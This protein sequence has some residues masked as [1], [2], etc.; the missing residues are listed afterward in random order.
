M[1]GGGIILYLRA[2]H[3]LELG[4]QELSTKETEEISN[5]LRQ[6][7]EVPITTRD[8]FRNYLYHTQD[9]GIRGQTAREAMMHSVKS[10][11]LTHIE[12]SY[13]LQEVGVVLLPKL[14][15]HP[16]GTRYADA[17]EILYSHVWYDINKDNTRTY[18]HAYY[19]PGEQVFN[20]SVNGPLVE[21]AE[22]DRVTGQY[23]G[24]RGKT[25]DAASYSRNTQRM[26]EFPTEGMSL[27]INSSS[28]IRTNYT[29]S[30][31]PKEMV[32]NNEWRRPIMW[33]AN[34]SN[35]YAFSAHDSIALPPLDADHPF[36]GFG[37]VQIST[38]F[39]FHSWD[40]IINK[41]ED[42]NTIRF[43]YDRDLMYI[44]SPTTNARNT[45]ECQSALQKRIKSHDREVMEKCSGS[46]STSNRRIQDLVANDDG[47]DTFSESTI[48]GERYYVSYKG[49]YSSKTT[50]YGLNA[51]NDPSNHYD[52]KS[53][54]DLNIA[55]VWARRSSVVREE[56]TEVI[57][58]FVV[59]VVGVFMMFIILFTAQLVIIG[60]PMKALVSATEAMANL[61]THRAHEVIQD[62]SCDCTLVRVTEVESLMRSFRRT[63]RFMSEYRAFMPQ[64]LRPDAHSE[65]SDPEQERSANV[66]LDQRDVKNLERL[67]NIGLKS[68]TGSV[69][70]ARF[71]IRDFKEG[72][73]AVKAMQFVNIVLAAVKKNSGIMLQ[74][75]PTVCIATWNTH[76]SCMRH[77]HLACFCALEIKKRSSYAGF[78]TASVVATG[79]LMAGSV[80]DCNTRAVAASGGVL[81]VVDQVSYLCGYLGISVLISADTYDRVRASVDA[82]VVD[83]VV[84]EGAEQRVTLVYELRSEIKTLPNS[85][86]APPGN[87]DAKD[88]YQQGWMLFTKGKFREACETL[89]QVVSDDRQV[90]RLLNLA[91]LFEKRNGK[92]PYVRKSRIP[93]E[94][95]EL[96]L[97]SSGWHNDPS[98]VSELT[99]HVSYDEVQELEQMLNRQHN[100]EAQVSFAVS[101][102]RGS[103]SSPLR[104][105]LLGGTH[106]LSLSRPNSSVSNGL[107]TTAC[108][109]MPTIDPLPPVLQT[110]KKHTVYT[111]GKVLGEGSYGKV[112]VGMTPDGELIALKCLSLPEDRNTVR[113]IVTEVSVLSKKRHEHIVAYHGSAVTKDNIVICMEYMPGGSLAQLL[114]HFG[115]FNASTVKRYTKDILKG[116]EFL[117]GEQILHRDLK[118][119]NVLVCNDGTCKLSDFGTCASL[120]ST[121]LGPGSTDASG[122]TPMVGTPLYM[123]PEVVQGERD[124]KSD[125][126]SFGIT[127]A[128]LL[129]GYVP[130]DID[131]GCVTPV[132]FA[133]LLG[134]KGLRPS[135]PEQIES[136]AR[137][138][139]ITALQEKSADRPNCSELLSSQYFT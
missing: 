133:Y 32:T 94:D 34:D 76:N 116:L 99:S 92:E 132:S 63:L 4:V 47:S 26:L 82:R 16:N 51:E 68:K 28:A 126:W 7:F 112:Y 43:V 67:Q 44:Y 74:T 89:E 95:F 41:H 22:I 11:S 36:H 17:R 107:V 97:P 105:T 127:M 71:D 3:A 54:T 8:G 108:S 111:S 24:E 29:D 40:V 86:P 70:E 72:E 136:T 9:R 64:G 62:S 123:A 137:A 59:F 66:E 96:Q 77:A 129:L 128:E 46:V 23:T 130:Y 110:T 78:K 101:P 15:T 119:G 125:I 45:E 21:V 60:R 117:H 56:I 61:D 106:S 6:F 88:L 69:L 58:I 103:S 104:A 84:L 5:R 27:E 49:V 135:I 38:Y 138:V 115:Q 79:R 65:S 87:A 85:T 33:I 42:E 25:F 81:E 98:V 91:R 100:E 90:V 124:V 19:M 102:K 73:G 57:I 75:S 52:N 31:S 53:R 13:I 50:K 120:A 131:S 134:I 113:D 37:A 2:V 18:V 14:K 1:V 118:P 122:M 30:D 35:A 48:D 20:E 109:E 55:V 121:A 80:G 93:W 83:K 12:T 114:Q 139:I 10:V 39:I